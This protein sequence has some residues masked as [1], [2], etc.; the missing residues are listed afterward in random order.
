M[1]FLLQLRIVILDVRGVAVDCVW[2]EVDPERK[3]LQPQDEHL[4]QSRDSI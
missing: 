3:L 1:S 2:G 4:I